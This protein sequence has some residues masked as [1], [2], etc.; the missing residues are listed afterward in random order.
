MSTTFA[1]VGFA[2]F[3]LVGVYIAWDIRKITKRERATDYPYRN[4]NVYEANAAGA[5]AVG[6]T[7]GGGGSCGDGGG[8]GSC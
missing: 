2:L 7:V 6:F 1:I 5:S 8:G 4:K 3:A